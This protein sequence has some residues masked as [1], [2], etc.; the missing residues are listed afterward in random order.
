ME[1][2][3][4]MSRSASHRSRSNNSPFCGTTWPIEQCKCLNVKSSCPDW[5][6]GTEL[7][8]EWFTKGAWGFKTPEF[9]VSDF[10][11]SH[12]VD[13]DCLFT[14]L[15][16]LFVLTSKKS[17]VSNDCWM[18]LKLELKMSHDCIREFSS[19]VSEESEELSFSKTSLCL[20][21]LGRLEALFWVFSLV[22]E[23]M[24]VWECSR[25]ESHDVLAA[26]TWLSSSDRMYP[27]RLKLHLRWLPD[28]VA[29]PVENRLP[30]KR[31][32]LD[33]KPWEVLGHLTCKLSQ[34]HF[35]KQIM[36]HDSCSHEV[37]L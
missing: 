14:D 10:S 12:E 4:C 21:S 37:Q 9:E 27:G 31:L 13:S 2:E 6:I 16:E 32:S 8:S 36:T 3:V 23:L 29:P 28:A 34:W 1:D 11:W 19:W 35:C 26:S 33:N 18:K 5:L 22:D 7:I 15:D 17:L 25:S 24:G 30:I 20:F